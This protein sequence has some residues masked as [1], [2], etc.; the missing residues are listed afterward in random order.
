MPLIVFP[1]S[2]EIVLDVTGGIFPTTTSDPIPTATGIAKTSGDSES[3]AVWAQGSAILLAIL[4]AVG[5]VISVI[6]RRLRRLKEHPLARR[7]RHLLKADRRMLQ[8]T[9]SVVVDTLPRYD[10]TEQEHATGGA[11]LRAR[12]SALVIRPVSWTWARMS[13]LWSPQPPAS[14]PPPLPPS[15]TGPGGTEGT[16]GA[17]DGGGGSRHAWPW[18]SNSRA[19]QPPQRSPTGSSLRIRFHQFRP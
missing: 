2:I 3:Q 14:P 16:A 8:T 17:S 11:G 4:V 7:E 19:G 6:R 9:T 5:L 18:T 15:P 12:A 10:T 13:T 1:N